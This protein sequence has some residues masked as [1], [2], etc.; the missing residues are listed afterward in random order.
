MSDALIYE[1]A[2]NLLC[3]EKIGSGIHRDV[4][5]CRLKLPYVVKV[6]RHEHRDRSFAN[7]LE[8][9]FW[10]LNEDYRKVADWLAPCVELSPDGRIMLQYRVDPL[11]QDYRLPERVPFFLNDIKRTNFG[12]FEGRL[13]TH[14]YSSHIET[15]NLRLRK[16]HWS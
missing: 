11:P 14:D 12:L 5:E 9:E 6:E 4:Y 15:V 2:F 8:Y 3:G 1:D 16:A 13:V 10:R 7:V